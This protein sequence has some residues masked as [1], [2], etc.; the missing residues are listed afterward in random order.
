[1][2]GLWSNIVR[3]SPPLGSARA[4]T[5]DVLLL[6]SRALSGARQG[7]MLSD[8]LDRLVQG[9][10]CSRGAAYSTAGGTLELVGEHGLPAALRAPLERLPLGGTSW[11]VAQLAAERR[12]LVVDRDLAA[13]TGGKLDRAALAAAGWEQAV[14]CPIAVGRQVFGALVLAWRA[15]D[16][17][18]PAVIA[19]LEIAC[20][21]VAFQAACRS[22]G[23]RRVDE[24]RSDAGAARMIA[25]GML[26]GGFAEDLGG[27]LTEARERLGELRRL[28]DALPSQPQARA[29]DALAARASGAITRAEQTGARFLAALETGAPERLD[30][31][32]VAADAV[33]L[34][35]PLLEARRVDVRL[36]PAEG[37][38]V[39]GRRSD[40]I[41]LFVQVLLNVTGALSDTAG[42]TSDRSA[43]IPRA[44]AISLE[45]VD[46]HEVIK[47]L[48]GGEDGAFARQSF[49]ETDAQASDHEVDFTVAR[50]IVVAHEGHIEVGA[51]N[52]GGANVSIILPAARGEADLAQR[53]AARAK[54]LPGSASIEGARPV[55]LWI[56]EDDLFLE[57]MVQSLQEF[58]V[59][60]ARSASEALQV[61]AFLKPSLIFCNVHLPDRSGHDLHVDVMARDADEAARFVFV[62]DGVLTPQVASYLIGSGRPTLMRPI[63]L[64]QVR[65]LARRDGSPP[66]RRA[67]APTLTD[68]RAPEPRP[69]ERAP[70]RADAAARPAARSGPREAPTSPARPAVRPSASETM[71]P[72]SPRPDEAASMRDHELEAI[73]KATADVLRREGPKRGASVLAMLR[74]RG[75]TESEALSVLTFALSKGVLLRDPPTS[76]MLRVPDAPSRRKVLVV[77]DDHDLRQ[78]LSE[79][80]TEEGYV[81]DTAANGLEAL[82]RLRQGSSHPVVVLDLMMPVMDGGQF[83]EELKRDPALSDTPVVVISANKTGFR[84]SDRPFL[85]KPLDYFKLVTMIDRSAKGRVRVS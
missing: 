59:R 50:R 65:A 64:D 28:L 85:S 25:L 77:D 56:D 14:A 61:L 32:R 34:V 80:L 72:P 76:T 53:Y 43:L 16:E 82:G 37:H 24:E 73:A 9:T 15:A 49:F 17:P 78:T 63:D 6:L 68:L 74:D 27:H 58:D 23:Q 36:S 39:V 44:F 67:G 5:L 35:K 45:R 51:A 13:N 7:G 71:R 55:I 70:A 47:V 33:A 20:S 42:A 19:A 8:T 21:L 57:I 1:M 81:V 26:A 69:V 22:D 48:D 41:Q 40:L 30:L 38:F 84:A 66:A 52:A 75:L 54:P 12:R 60:V 31:A 83:L 62:A 29:L 79:V 2:N 18:D 10:G 3:S 46:G 4:S 11:F